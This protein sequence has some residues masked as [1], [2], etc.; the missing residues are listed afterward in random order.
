MKGGPRGGDG[1]ADARGEKRKAKNGKR[2]GVA[3]G[4]QIGLAFVPRLIATAEFRAADAPVA[5]ERSFCL[6]FSS[7]PSRA[8]KKFSN[9]TIT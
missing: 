7:R 1:G 2:K 4:G 6:R 5:K 8:A 3:A 9:Y